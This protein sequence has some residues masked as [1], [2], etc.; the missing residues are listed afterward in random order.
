MTTSH[1]IGISSLI[2]ALL[3]TCCASTAQGQ[4]ETWSTEFGSPGFTS[5]TYAL[6]TFDDGTGPM[7]WVGGDV[8]V[9]GVGLVEITRWNGHGW[10]WAGALNDTVTCLA[11][12]DNGNGPVMYAGGYFTFASG[13]KGFAFWNGS[14]WS[15]LGGGLTNGTSYVWVNAMAAF[16]HGTGN[17]LYI[18]GAF[19]ASGNGVFANH[20]IKWNGS[21]SAVGGGLGPHGTTGPTVYALQVFDDGTG[22]A[23]YV[24]GVFGSA[25]GVPVNGIAKWDGVQWS[26][27]GD[28]ADLCVSFAVFDDGSG[29]ALY[30]AA[31]FVNTDGVIA[32]WNGTQWVA[33]PHPLHLSPAALL[34]FNDGNSDALYSGGFGY[35]IG[36]GSTAVGKWDG[37]GW[38]TLGGGVS[39]GTNTVQVMEAFPSNSGVGDDLFVGG[40]FTKAGGIPSHGLGKWITCH[41]QIDT[42]CP[43]D[44]TLALCPCSNSGQVGHGCNNSAATGGAQLSA[45]GSSTPDTLVFTCT[46]ELPHA[47]SIVLQGDAVTPFVQWFGSGL[48][49]AGGNTL[50]LFTKT[51]SGGTITAPQPG[52]PSVSTRSAALG[53]VI[54][55]GAIRYYQVYYRDPNA[56]FCPSGGL[57]NISNGLRVVW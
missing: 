54:P 11:V 28:G 9:P 25:G 24:G 51:A 45:S 55:P 32:R 27:V 2:A 20:F 18:G 22:P 12:Y 4:C 50:R 56:S 3:A 53:D 42:V 43:G 37:H 48:L 13:E 8:V 6:K 36:P 40:G 26:A 7:L 52:D 33:L 41:D 49:C 5:T 57:F 39:G 29:P 19:T 35:P 44:Q 46:Y 30:G 17:E 10:V 16:N 38:T 14:A 34:A 21:W 23:L 47:L 31:T 15:P 1:R